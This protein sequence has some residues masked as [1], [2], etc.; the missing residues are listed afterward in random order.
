VVPSVFVSCTSYSFVKKKGSYLNF[1]PDQFGKEYQ[2]LTENFSK[3]VA[4][5]KNKEGQFGYGVACLSIFVET[6]IVNMHLSM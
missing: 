2:Y 1:F 4:F 5:K 3:H 6:C